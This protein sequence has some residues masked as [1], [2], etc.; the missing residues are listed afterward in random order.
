MNRRREQ[1]RR[2]QP[3]RR[4][5]E[6]LRTAAALA[7]HDVSQLRAGRADASALATAI[8]R[9]DRARAEAARSRREAGE[10]LAVLYDAIPNGVGL[11]EWVEG[12]G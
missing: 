6:E 4:R 3:A 10:L 5:A 1:V 7:T 12:R 8:Q 2:V 11:Q 9:A